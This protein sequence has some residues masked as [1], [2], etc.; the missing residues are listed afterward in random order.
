MSEIASPSRS[1]HKVSPVVRNYISHHCPYNSAH[2]AG[3]NLDV[4]YEMNA[5]KQCEPSTASSLCYFAENV[6][7]DTPHIHHLL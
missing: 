5:R 4:H 1:W 6:A 2:I 7:N 3:I